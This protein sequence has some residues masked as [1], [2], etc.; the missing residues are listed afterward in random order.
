MVRH[1]SAPHP[2]IAIATDD[3]RIHFLK[4]DPHSEDASTVYEHVVFRRAPEA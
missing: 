4:R 1:L 3:S 2:Q